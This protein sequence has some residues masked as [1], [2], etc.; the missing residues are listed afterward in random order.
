MFPSR[1][2]SSS[3]PLKRG[4]RPLSPESQRGVLLPL[5]LVFGF[6]LHLSINHQGQIMA[7]KITGGNIG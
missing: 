7:V 2:K 5:V 4:E 1:E 6:K 3:S